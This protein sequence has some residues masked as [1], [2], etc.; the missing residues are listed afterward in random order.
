MRRPAHSLDPS[1]PRLL[2]PFV[3]VLIVLLSSCAHPPRSTHTLGEGGSD[4]V[5]GT[6]AAVRE[7]RTLTELGKTRIGRGE[8]SAGID[9]LVSALAVVRRHQRG[10]ERV[11]A[12][13]LVEQEALAA[14]ER[15]GRRLAVEPSAGWRRAGPALFEPVAPA[16]G[17]SGVPR[18]RLLYRRGDT[19][20]PVPG[21]AYEFRP[22]RDSAPGPVPVHVGGRTDAAGGGWY[23]RVGSGQ[24][25]DRLIRLDF[26][27]EANGMTYRFPQPVTYFAIPDP[28]VL[29]E[30]RRGERIG[31]LLDRLVRRGLVTEEAFRQVA[32]TGEYPEFPFVPPPGSG[33]RRF[34][35]LFRP[36]RYLLPGAASPPRSFPAVMGCDA[37]AH[38]S[39]AAERAADRLIRRLLARSADRFLRTAA[40]PGGLSVREQVI[41]ASIVEKEAAAGRDH[42]RVA[43][44]F[45]NRLRMGSRLASC[46]AVEY[47]LG[48]HRPFLTR[49]DISIDSP[50]NLYLRHGLPPTP[51]CFFGDEALRAVRSPPQ[52]SLLYFVFDWT[53]GE[54]LFATLYSEHLENAEHARSNYVRKH[55]LDSLHEIRYDKFYEE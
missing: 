41:L 45:H 44:V 26:R 49:R 11:D 53:T 1:L 32:A 7:A 35:G 18:F 4:G 30:V 31:D 14:L 40:V 22:L 2:L 37:A 12:L 38:E 24:P 9:D 33:I 10:P 54:L 6:E 50:H 5:H 21:L 48:Y 25:R 29:I 43:S 27:S 34:E 55:G 47:A 3:P 20:H 46:P 36:G 28:D 8:V 52:S 51:I 23:G 13:A 19:V 39:E 15:T 16:F 17:E 42:G